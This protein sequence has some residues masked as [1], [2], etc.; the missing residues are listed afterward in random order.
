MSIV[1]SWQIVFESRQ[2]AFDTQLHYLNCTIYLSLPPVPEATNSKLDF[3]F[4]SILFFDSERISTHI[5]FLL[6]I[7]LSHKIKIK[8]AISKLWQQWQRWRII[9]WMI[10]RMMMLVMW[11]KLAKLCEG[12]ERRSSV[13][14]TFSP[15]HGSFSPVC[16]S[17]TFSPFVQNTNN[18]FPCHHPSSPV[19]QSRSSISIH[20][21]QCSHSS[22][23]RLNNSEQQGHNAF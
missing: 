6:S 2:Y 12:R 17:S 4:T 9:H 14:G 10:M 20:F 1:E 13:G 7:H 5:R 8:Q 3:Q 23:F 19:S 11:I 16:G 18:R 21:P 15:A 22:I